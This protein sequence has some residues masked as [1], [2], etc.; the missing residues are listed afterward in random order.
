[1]ASLFAEC[2]GGILTKIQKWGKGTQRLNTIVDH[3]T[4]NGTSYIC[5]LSKI[6]YHD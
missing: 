5:A 2:P 3:A 6:I 1:M 4:D